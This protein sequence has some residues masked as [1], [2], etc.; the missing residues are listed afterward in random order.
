MV[1]NTH[2]CSSMLQKNTLIHTQSEPE[3]VTLSIAPILFRTQLE[4]F[5]VMLKRKKSDQTTQNPMYCTECITTTVHIW[6]IT[7]TILSSFHLFP[8]S[9]HQI[10][11]LK[12]P[13]SSSSHWNIQAFIYFGMRQTPQ[14]SFSSFFKIILMVCLLRRH[15]KITSASFHSLVLSLAPPWGLETSQQSVLLLERKFRQ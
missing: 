10:S 9:T 2:I 6:C 15:L 12:A 7:V 1:K 11:P 3:A 13:S 8:S 4:A 5:S 14:A